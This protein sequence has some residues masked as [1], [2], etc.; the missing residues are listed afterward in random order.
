MREFGNIEEFLMKILGKE[1]YD[2]FTSEV[3]REHNERLSMNNYE[4]V[5]YVYGILIFLIG[6]DKNAIK[7]DRFKVRMNKAKMIE[8]E[9]DEICK[10]YSRYID[11][12]EKYKT[13]LFNEIQKI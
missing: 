7:K 5:I 11:K 6:M 2:F 9:V 8:I 3:A 4:G 12:I 1:E 13:I 10:K